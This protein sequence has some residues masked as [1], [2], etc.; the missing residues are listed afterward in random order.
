MPTYFMLSKLTPKGRQTL[1]RKPDRLA[2]VNLEIK[3]LGY[4]VLA[5]WAVMGSYDFVTIVEA[6]SNEKIAELSILLGSRGTIMMETLPAIP[7]ERF[8]DKLRGPRHLGHD[9]KP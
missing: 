7:L 8:T 2:H 9:A 5:Q 4:K 3:D 6:E 1:D